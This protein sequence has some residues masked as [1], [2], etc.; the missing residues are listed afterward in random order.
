M[1]RVDNL[2]LW[3]VRDK[4]LSEEYGDGG[5]HKP[6]HCEYYGKPPMRAEIVKRESRFVNLSGIGDKKYVLDS[7][8]VLFGK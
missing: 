8:L 5:G 7:Q 4:T 3:G 6:K 2:C 1:C